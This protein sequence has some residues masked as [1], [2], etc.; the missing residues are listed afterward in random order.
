VTANK[1][2]KS[3]MPIAIITMGQQF[4]FAKNGFLSRF[5]IEFD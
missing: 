2:A 3:F 4:F 1:S 5:L